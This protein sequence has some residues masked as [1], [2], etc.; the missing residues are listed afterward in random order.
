MKS[1]SGF[2]LLEIMIVVSIIGLLAT[3][4]VPSFMSSRESTQKQLCLENQ[5]LIGDMLDLYCLDKGTAPL[6]SN[7]G[8]LCAVRDALVPLN[9]DNRYIANRDVFE[10]PASGD[11]DQHDYDLVTSDG[12]VVGFVCNVYAKHNQ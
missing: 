8:N 3:I 5:R 6:T 2:T 10:C 12:M 4:A 7:F 11:G 1:T 9:P